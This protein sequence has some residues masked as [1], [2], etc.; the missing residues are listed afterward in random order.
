MIKPEAHYSSYLA[1]AGPARIRPPLEKD[2]A[3]VHALIENAPQLDTN[4]CYTY[5][6]QAW[7]FA[8]TCAYAEIAGI[9]AGYVA[10]FIPPRQPDILFIWQIVIAPPLRGTGLAREMVQHLLQRPACSVVRHIETTVA[11]GNADSERFF[12]KLGAALGTT[13][14]ISERLPAIYFR[15]SA[16]A[17][18]QLFHIGPISHG[19]AGAKA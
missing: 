11:R 1:M 3:L 13:L 17:S 2:A 19:N 15:P 16:H 18:E 14:T 5:L 8:D 6:L 12:R 9:P 7:H 4:S 10:G